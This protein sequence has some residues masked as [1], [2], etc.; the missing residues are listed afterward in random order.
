MHRALDVGVELDVVRDKSD[1]VWAAGFWDEVA[2]T[3]PWCRRVLVQL[4]ENTLLDEVVT[5]GSAWALQVCRDW[6]GTGGVV[7]RDLAVLEA[8]LERVS[9]HAAIGG[10]VIVE[11]IGEFII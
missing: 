4:F 1:L 5:Q 10:E 3:E 9:K 7:W 11:D 6:T 8:D 2:A